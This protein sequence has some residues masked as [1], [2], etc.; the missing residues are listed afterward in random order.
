[1]KP[2]G[3]TRSRI[4]REYAL[5][6]PDSF[7]N[8]SLPGWGKATITMLIA[9]V[10]GA[11]FT[12]FLATFEAGGHAGPAASGVERVI[13]VIEGELTVTPSGQPARHLKAGGFAFLPANSDAAIR[14]DSA[15]RVNVFEKQYVALADTKPPTVI[16]GDS[17]NVRGEPFMGDADAR[18]QVLLPDDPAFDMAVNVFT[19]QPGARL[20]Q[21]EIHA[22]EHG[23][24][25]LS[26]EGV[27]RLGDDWHPVQAGDVIWMASY[28]PQWFVAMGKQPASYLYYKDV[29]RDPLGLVRS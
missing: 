11:R 17:R 9:P 12:Q 27:Y 15:A 19:Y 24:I 3:A 10:I 20:P 16:I 18:L 8:S 1:M 23:L 25:M 6:C 7:V 26:G 14:A 4:A 22:M 29:N 2:F 5:I 21:V 13:F 28:C